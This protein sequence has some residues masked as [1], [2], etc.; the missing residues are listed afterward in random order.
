MLVSIAQ[1]EV[2]TALS[3]GDARTFGRV[4]LYP[5]G[6]HGLITSMRDGDYKSRKGSKKDI[7]G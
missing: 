3:F 4:I 6:G 2:Y 7:S 5:G 1:L